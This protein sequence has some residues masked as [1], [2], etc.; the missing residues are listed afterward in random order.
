MMLTLAVHISLP[1]IGCLA[2]VGAEVEGVS[3]GATLSE[4]RRSTSLAMSLKIFDISVLDILRELK[5]RQNALA[6]AYT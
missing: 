6:P 2:R 3:A 1:S 4:F 5:P